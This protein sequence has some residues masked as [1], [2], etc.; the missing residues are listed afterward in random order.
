MQTIGRIKRT[1]SEQLTVSV[2]T[3][4]GSEGIDARIFFRDID[5][6]WKPT[7]R[8]IRIRF[9]EAEALM[10]LIQKAL[11]TNKDKSGIE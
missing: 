7:K 11:N 10:R 9:D 4:A 8:G 2:Q 5:G 6:K 1:E 3:F